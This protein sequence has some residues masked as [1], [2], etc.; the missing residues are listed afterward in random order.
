[1]NT[2]NERGSER[3]RFVRYKLDAKAD[4]VIDNHIT[5]HGD[6]HDIST[7]GMFLK[8]KTDI[9]RKHL[10]KNVHAF[11]HA[12]ALGG[13]VNIEAGCSIVRITPEGLAL[14]FSAID[15]ANRKILHD[16]IGELNEMV[17]R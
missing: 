14:F 5:E 2:N 11:I 13:E 6:V 17:R 4:I 9:S 7:G 8:L 15:S 12:N 3:R 16:L 10:D 1:M